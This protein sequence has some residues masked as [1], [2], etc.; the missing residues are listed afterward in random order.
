MRPLFLIV[1]VVAAGGIYLWTSSGGPEWSSNGAEIYAKDPPV[2]I[3]DNTSDG[4]EFKGYTVTPLADFEVNAKVLSR[5]D[6]SRGREAEL[7]PIDL[8]L[9]WGDMTNPDVLSQLEIS[10][11]GR[12]YHWR[13]KQ[14]P[15][16][17]QSIITQSANMHIVP[18]DEFIKDNL[19]DIKRG[20]VV[21][22]TGQLVRIEADDGWRWS[23][24]LT[25]K[26]TGNGA[27]EVVFVSEFD[28]LNL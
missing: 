26:D 21:R 13:A 14:L 12:F 25:R 16:P 3:D 10:Q 19:K 8:A 28:I 22:L 15:L 1:S 11:K 9:G 20:D 7:S 24:S 18:A 27:C 5:H 17:M 6:Y 4:F 2:Q 23:S